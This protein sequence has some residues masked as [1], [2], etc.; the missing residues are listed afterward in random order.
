M[1]A[2]LK[3]T[4]GRHC[5]AVTCAPSQLFYDKEYSQTASEKVMIIEVANSDVT[6]GVDLLKLMIKYGFGR[7]N[8]GL[9]STTRDFVFQ[10]FKALGATELIVFDGSC[11]TIVKVNPE[12]DTE[13]YKKETESVYALGGTR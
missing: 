13:Q 10:F 2:G 9:E 12:F 3:E 6:K 8:R 4:M 11:S 1:D 7:Y 5:R